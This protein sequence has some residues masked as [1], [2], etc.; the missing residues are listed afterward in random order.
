MFLAGIPRADNTLPILSRPA[1]IV[2]A[3]LA[4]RRQGTAKQ[5]PIYRATGH[6]PRH[7]PPA[8][9]RPATGRQ[10][11][12][13]T[14]PTNPQTTTAPPTQSHPNAG[15]AWHPRSVRFGL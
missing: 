10:N 15:R 1:H 5:A 4:H 7:R 14:T 6:Q 11:H 3:K 13:Q 12:P 9:H 8:G 2:L